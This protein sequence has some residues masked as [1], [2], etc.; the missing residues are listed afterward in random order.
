M[1]DCEMIL[2]RE[3]TPNY[4][5]KNRKAS[6]FRNF[7]TA[8]GTDCQPPGKWRAAAGR[9]AEFERGVQLARTGQQTLQQAEQR[10]RILLNDDKDADLTSFTPEQD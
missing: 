7:I 6:Q 2:N 8:A 9:G 3:S 5:E 4:A 10:V 1:S